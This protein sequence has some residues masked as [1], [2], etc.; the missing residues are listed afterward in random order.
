MKIQLKFFGQLAEITGKEIV[1]VDGIEDTDSLVKRMLNEF[2]KLKSCK[3][4]IAVDQKLLKQ[5][6]QLK[7]VSEVAFLPPFAGG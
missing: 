3:F 4:Q 5:N 7:S 2:P 1:E 6:Q